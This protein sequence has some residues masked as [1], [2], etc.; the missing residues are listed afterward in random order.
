MY[1]SQ[2]P[3]HVLPF[4]LLLCLGRTP[5]TDDFNIPCYVLDIMDGGKMVFAIAVRNRY[6]AFF[7]IVIPPATGTA[8]IAIADRACFW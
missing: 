5:P 3:K 8:Y 7:A 2:V 1:L 4:H 6:T